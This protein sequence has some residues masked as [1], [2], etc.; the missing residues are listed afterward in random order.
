MIYFDDLDLNEV[1]TKI[2]AF[3]TH[4]VAEQKP[5]A[6]VVY[7]YYD[8]CKYKIYQNYFFLIS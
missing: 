5:A 1:C 8:N 2:K 6:I 4:A 7:D 3:R